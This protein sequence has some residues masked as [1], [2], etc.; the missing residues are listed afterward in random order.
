MYKKTLLTLTVLALASLTAFAADKNGAYTSV[1]GLKTYTA[2]VK[3]INPSVPAG[4]DPV[5]F[6]NLANKYPKGVYFCCE[7]GTIAGATSIIGEEIWDAVA[8]TPASNS[9]VKTLK[10]AISYVYGTYTDVIISLNAD[11][12]GVPCSTPLKHWKE[13]LMT[14]TFGGCC[15]LEVISNKN[16]SLTAGTQYWIVASTEAASDIWAA[17]NV[18]VSDQVDLGNIAQCVNC[19]SGGTW[20]GYQTNLGYS[21]QAGGTV[22]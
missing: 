13:T 22:P 21:L 14:Q 3:V 15:A 19:S 8:F 17:W 2:P 12:S 10:F 1:D 5:I 4:K 7:G 20:S 6:S 16:V 9:H 11:C 18:E